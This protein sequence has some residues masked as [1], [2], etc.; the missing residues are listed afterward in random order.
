MKYLPFIWAALWRKPVEALLIWLAT[1]SAF[2]LFGLMVGLNVTTQRVIDSAR[3]DRL[4]VLMRF[5]DSPFTGL[6]VALGE[7]LASLEGVT[8]VGRFRWLSG[9]HQRPDNRVSI[10]A[11]DEGMRR[12]WSEISFDI[13]RSGIDWSPRRRGYTSVARLQSG[14]D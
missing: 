9:Y 5:P 13:R 7:D 11:V 8:G 14:S 4:I 6:P 10:F 1:T 3:M 12:A 2:T